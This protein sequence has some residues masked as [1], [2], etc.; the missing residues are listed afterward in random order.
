MHRIASDAELR[1]RAGRPVVDGSISFGGTSTAVN[2]KVE[3][4]A[5][6]TVFGDQAYK[7]P[8]SSTKSMMGHLIA[9][10]GAVELIC[11]VL[12]IR[13]NMLPPTSAQTLGA[14]G[15]LTLRRITVPL[16]AANLHRLLLLMPGQD[17]HPTA[18]AEVHQ[19]VQRVLDADIIA[20][21]KAQ[22]RPGVNQG[23]I[24]VNPA[25][26]LHS[27]PGLLSSSDRLPCTTSSWLRAST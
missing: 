18:A 11:C 7:I 1:A 23:D 2:D 6:K 4:L 3:S 19:R 26:R 8:V 9:A 13:D 15:F 21:G 24:R 12:A 10:A 25:N 17:R 5:I 14:S 20:A 27:S 22:V 16:I